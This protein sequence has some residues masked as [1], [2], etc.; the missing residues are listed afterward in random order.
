M[1]KNWDVPA[2]YR[3]FLKLISH[4]AVNSQDNLEIPIPFKE[5]M[6]L[7]QNKVPVYMRTRNILGQIDGGSELGIK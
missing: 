1:K 2:D 4:V 6:P 7:P 5:D 3:A